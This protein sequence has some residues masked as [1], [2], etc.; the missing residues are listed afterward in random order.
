MKYEMKSSR[1][2]EVLIFF[3]VFGCLAICLFPYAISGFYF[4]DI[5]N[6]LVYGSINYGDSTFQQYLSNQLQQWQLHGRFFPISITIISYIWS[7]SDSLFEYRMIHL[8]FIFLN[9]VFFYVLVRKISKSARFSGLVIIL[10]PLFF[11]F[12][13][14]WDGISSFGPL[15]QLALLFVLVTWIFLINFIE[16]GS[17]KLLVASLIFEFLSLGT[18]ELALIVYPVQLL[19]LSFYKEKG[20]II[21]KAGVIL[22]TLVLLIYLAITFYLIVN[23]DHSYDGVNIGGPSLSAYF[24]QF[25]SAFPLSFFANTLLPIDI[26]FAVMAILI[27]AYTALYYF[28]FNNYAAKFSDKMQINNIKL[29]LLIG[30]II[31]VIPPML[32]SISS[33]YKNIVSYGDPYIVVYFQYWGLA[34]VLAIFINYFFKKSKKIAL[35]I[36]VIIVSITTSA[37]LARINIKNNQFLLPRDNTKTAI[38][39]GLMDELLEGD[40]LIVDSPFP[41]EDDANCAAYFGMALKK[42]IY[43]HS[44]ESLAR[45]ESVANQI[46]QKQVKSNSRI[47]LLTNE[48]D[49]KNGNIITLGSSDGRKIE[50]IDNFGQHKRLEFLPSRSA[51]VTRPI[52]LGGFYGWEPSEKKEWAWSKGD[53]KI[54]FYNLA[55]KKIPVNLVFLIDSPVDQRI[56]INYRNNLVYNNLFKSGSSEKISI[57]V[58][59]DP[60]I[61]E[62]IIISSGDPVALSATDNRLFSY[63]LH[64][65]KLVEGID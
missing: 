28:Y 10:L 62:F 20:A 1:H 58:K 40:I 32:I 29:L 15:N 63:R 23:R 5:Y 64:N 22:C 37:N 52:L 60:G 3:A 9:C 24:A 33:K 16:S 48:F 6:S 8:V 41:W 55:N 54:V 4:D 30:F 19:L 65:I 42:R 25:F 31:S 51:L 34:L 18:Y 53:A 46:I 7:F 14:R 11:Q 56:S 45:S 17:F 39:N 21:S 27:F 50:S 59:M 49:I 36:I 2:Q 13:P 35:I 43:C 47:Y 12:N 61:N 44:Y 26:N 57:N 38:K